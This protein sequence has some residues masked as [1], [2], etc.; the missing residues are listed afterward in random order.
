M[1]KFSL[2]R[3][4]KLG[5]ILACA[6]LLGIM[7]LFGITALRIRSALIEVNENVRVPPPIPTVSPFKKYISIA[8]EDVATLNSPPKNFEPNDKSTQNSSKLNAQK[9]SNFSLAG[10]NTVLN[11]ELGPLRLCDMRCDDLKEVLVRI[12]KYSKGDLTE[13]SNFFID[14]AF[15]LAARMS[16]VGLGPPGKTALQIMYQLQLDPMSLSSVKELSKLFLSVDDILKAMASRKNTKALEADDLM[17]VLRNQ[18]TSCQTNQWERECSTL[19]T[20]IETWVSRG[21][22][23]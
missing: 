22:R 16:Q 13:N 7:L 1:N 9:R 10:M 21:G 8:S 12:K 2:N 5:L 3:A 15:Q 20:E 4:I 6:I 14:P 11:S 23:L 17:R 18:A 19:E